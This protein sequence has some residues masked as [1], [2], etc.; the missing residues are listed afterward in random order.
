MPKGFTFNVFDVDRF[1]TREMYGKVLAQIGQTNRDIV[2]LTA[3]LMRSNKT[4]DFAKVCPERFFNFGIAEQ[5]MMAAAAGLAV[6]G[7]LPY[8]STYAAFASLRCAEQVRTDIA[9]PKLPVRIVSSHAGLSMGNGGTTHHATED[10]AI[11][12]SMANMT[13]IVPADANECAKAVIESITYPGPIYMRLGRGAEPIV[14]KAD[15]E[16]KIGKAVTVREGRDVTV[17]ACGIAVMAAIKAA[18]KLEAEGI[19]VR[20][21]DMHTIKPL[22]TEAI[23][24]AARETGAII[25]VEEHNIIGGLG[26]AVA[27]TLADAGLGIR[28]LRLGI[29]DIYSTIGQ[30]DDLYQRYGL[31]QDGVFRAI[32]S[33]LQKG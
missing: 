10:I 18:R 24:K 19:S 15:Y 26:G 33:V 21:I 8:V 1:A 3:D 17:I 11:T 9:Y 28:F 6:N 27:E 2:V 30:P 13:V 29:P 20:I 25:T 22:D 32:K 5:N 7:K 23:L 14:Y 12:R 16:F 31:D 4:G